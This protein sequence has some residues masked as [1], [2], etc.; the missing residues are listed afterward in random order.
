M[1]KAQQ[2]Q[3]RHGRDRGHHPK[4]HS[5]RV[6]VRELRCDKLAEDGA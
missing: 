4:G 6:V 2:R 5:V 1:L 3:Q